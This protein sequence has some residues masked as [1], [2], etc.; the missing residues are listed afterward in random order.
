MRQSRKRL[1]YEASLAR[2]WMLR[3]HPAD[4]TRIQEAARKRY[5]L[6]LR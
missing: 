6:A 4:M 1:Q 3:H 2:R 5:P